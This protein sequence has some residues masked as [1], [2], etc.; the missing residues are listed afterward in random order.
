[1][2][3]R[4]FP[5]GDEASRFLR[6]TAIEDTGGERLP[7]LDAAVRRIGHAI[8]NRERMVVFG[9]YD[10][11]GTAAAAIMV[12]L[13]QMASNGEASIG[14][15]LPSR[16]EGYGLRP[17][18]VENIAASGTSLLI[19]VDCGS[20]DVENVALARALGLDVVVFD[21]HRI[22][23]PPVDAI[24]VSPQLTSDTELRQLSAA[25]VVYV[26]S[27]AL[28]EAGF[29]LGAGLGRSP[30]H[31]LDLTTLGLVA[32][33]MPLSGVVRSL[34]RDGLDHLSAWRRPG[35]RALAH[36]AGMAL[37]RVTSDDIAYKIAP[38][39][40]AAG[41]MGDPR[42]ALGLL[43]TDDSEVA[44]R[45]VTRLDQLNQQRKMESERVVAEALAMVR[46]QPDW[47]SQR[48]SLVHAPG[49]HVGVLGVAAARLAEALARPA[50]VLSDADGVSRG[51]ARSIPGFDIGGAIAESAELLIAHGGHEQAA[52]LTIE[53]A[54]IPTFASALDDAAARA[55]LA[56]YGVTLQIDADLPIE[57]LELAT[58]E[59]LR[60]LEPYGAGNPRPLLRL[61]G[62]RLNSYR[63]LGQDGRHLKLFVATPRGEVG[64]LAWNAAGRS[65]ELVGR[66]RLDLL[67]TLDEDRWN[68]Q[69]R[70]QP[71]LRDFRTL[72]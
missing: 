68:G 26:F 54:L 66:R 45:R 51:S 34:V 30:T 28:A 14:V 16:A 41:R 4:R 13:L 72:D 46:V 56:R 22:V 3:A 29:D 33:V 61:R 6:G 64:V 50:V 23:G 9:D 42:L 58:V 27:Q 11:D 69:R 25:G 49:W 15:R 10:V 53:S 48:V 17:E 52:G 12:Q 67:L 37:D 60:V 32:D 31:L 2:L 7:N 36:R 24:V 35:L 5:S 62:A 57:R 55:D 1:V 18:V 44:E 47:E 21:H 20:S 38:R 19:T 71:V 59:A 63:S 39:L 8:H 40:N 70:L 65:R 43:L